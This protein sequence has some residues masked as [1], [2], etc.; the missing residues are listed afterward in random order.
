MHGEWPLYHRVREVRS[1]WF[2][3]AFVPTSAVALAP[4][5]FG[6]SIVVAA[7]GY[8]ILAARVFGHTMRH[9][10]NPARAA[11]YAA[12]TTLGKVPQ[13]IGQAKFVAA[14]LRGRRSALIEYK[15]AR[16]VVAANK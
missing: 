9:R 14:R 2:W 5:T 1:N 15:A 7:A 10:R 8:A 16:V 6:A 12:F 4:A 3:G 11:T 13:A